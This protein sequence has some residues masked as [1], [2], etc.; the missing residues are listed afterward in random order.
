MAERKKLYSY[1]EALKAVKQGKMIQRKGWNGKGL[2]VFMQVPSVIDVVKTV[3][4][5]QSLPES[6]KQEFLKREAKHKEQNIFSKTNTTLQYVN[7]MAIVDKKNKIQGWSPSVAD[8]LEED[9][10]IID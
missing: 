10:Y 5:M 6:V 7:Q 9:W 8:T 3:P 2:F 1:S 4:K